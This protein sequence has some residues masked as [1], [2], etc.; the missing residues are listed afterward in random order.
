[1]K[2]A[3]QMIGDPNH[4]LQFFRPSI[5]RPHTLHSQILSSTTL[6]PAF[7]KKATSL[8]AS[9]A[10][11]VAASICKW[12][13]PHPHTGCSLKAREMKYF[14]QRRLTK[15]SALFWGKKLDVKYMLEI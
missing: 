13:N 6:S 10:D 14:M 11:L 2:S 3:C 7:L 9:S 15:A 4:T 1:M 12:D 8:A 5:C